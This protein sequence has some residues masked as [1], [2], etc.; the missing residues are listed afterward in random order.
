MLVASCDS[1]DVPPEVERASVV[2]TTMSGPVR[3]TEVGGVV[4]F[5]GVPYA[6]PPLGELRWR[7]PVS[8]TPWTDVR[9]AS[10]FGASCVQSADFEGPGSEDCLFINVWT[11]EVRSAEPRPVMFYIH[12][13]GWVR[14]AGNMSGMAGIEN[15]LDGASLAEA[16]DAVVITLNYRLGSLGFL[17]HPAFGSENDSGSAG[18]YGLMD[19]IFG[20]QWVRENAR[21]FGGDPERVLVFGTSAGGSQTCAVAASPL[22][23]GLFSVAAAHSSG[24][25]D[26]FE[27]ETATDLALRLAEDAGC[28]GAGDVAECLRGVPAATLAALPSSGATADGSVLPMCPL[29][30]FEAGGGSDVPLIFGTMAHEAV[31][32]LNDAVR[33]LTWDEFHALLDASFGAQGPAI[34]SV[35]PASEYESAGAAWVFFAGDWIYHCPERRIFRALQGRA[36]P[37]YRF[38]FGGVLSD[39]RH[40]EHGATH[41]T[42]VPFVFGN[43]G[44]LSTTPEELALSARM[45][46]IWAHTA[47]TGGTPPSEWTPWDELNP[48]LALGLE[49]VRMI[50]GYRDAQCDQL[51]K[52]PALREITVLP[53]P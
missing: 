30:L 53:F 13:G 20:L 43:F 11:P 46:S 36:E 37:S 19:V 47:R 45:S 29:D 25:C 27:S 6:S 28:D 26:C 1:S 17:A 31:L 4:R 2:A 50:S 48:A 38:V 12:G 32:Y 7:P 5:L 51:D 49:D 10:S 39:P 23:E 18:N 16:E 15:T 8:P 44:D 40:V 14:G 42:D 35:Y 3:G 33:N 22:A 41:G 9:D 52:V 24:G 21:E 34:A